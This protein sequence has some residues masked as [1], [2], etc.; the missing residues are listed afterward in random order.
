MLDD[1]ETARGPGEDDMEAEEEYRGSFEEEKARSRVNLQTGRGRGRRDGGS[2]STLDDDERSDDDD[3]D[4]AAHEVSAFDAMDRLDGGVRLAARV[5]KSSSSARPF[6]STWICT[7]LSR[8]AAKDDSQHS[9]ETA[10]MAKDAILESKACA[11]FACERYR[12]GGVV[13]AHVAVYAALN[14]DQETPTM[15]DEIHAVKT[16]HIVRL[17]KKDV[18]ERRA[19]MR[20]DGD[21]RLPDIDEEANARLAQACTDALRDALSV[22]SLTNTSARHAGAME[23]A[24]AREKQI[25]RQRAALEAQALVLR[26]AGLSLDDPGALELAK[27]LGI[28]GPRRVR[29]QGQAVARSVA[30]VDAVIHLG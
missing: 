17:V 10:T 12:Y 7:T 29:R 18:K 6:D 11:K 13:G 2:A 20:I 22:H 14:P 23:G 15:V 25:A 19:V 26:E 16:E 8:S 28:V 27:S 1:W 4:D 30:G 9:K 5:V 24:A 3:D 21:T